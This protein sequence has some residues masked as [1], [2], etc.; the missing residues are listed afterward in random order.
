MIPGNKI[1]AVGDINID[2]II[3][4]KD[5]KMEGTIEEYS[6]TLGGSTL[7]SAIILA[8]SKVC[9][10]FY[11][12]IGE[13]IPTQFLEKLKTLFNDLYFDKSKEKNGMV[14]SLSG[15]KDRKML[16]YRGS[17]REKISKLPQKGDIL[18]L[19]SYYLIDH[20][21]DIN[22][23]NFKHKILSIGDSKIELQKDLVNKFDLIFMNEKHYQ[24]GNYINKIKNSELIVTCGE[25]GSFTIFNGKKIFEKQ[26]NK[27]KVKDTTGAGDTFLA[28][29]VYSRI[30]KQNDIKTSLKIGN[31][32]GAMATTIFGTGLLFIKN[33]LDL[34]NT[35]N[36]NI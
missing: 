9:V 31:Y 6:F 13:G 12:V 32:C 26:T 14:I 20:G 15:E 29:Y 24:I 16:S 36:L 2:I 34:S 27:V 11:G 5:D 28:G 25:K 18:L 30:I 22:L 3:K 4:Y 7:N 23:D 17:N 8:N 35:E 1:V 21:L 33:E 19:S 10:D